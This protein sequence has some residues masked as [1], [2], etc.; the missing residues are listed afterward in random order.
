LSVLRHVRDDLTRRWTTAG[1]AHPDGASSSLNDDLSNAVPHLMLLVG[2]DFLETFAIPDLWDPNDIEEIVRDFG[3]IV[4]SRLG[5]DPQKFV[6]ESDILSKYQHNIHIVTEW[7]TNEISSTRIRRALRRGES[8]KYLVADKVISYINQY[9]L[10][11]EQPIS[12]TTNGK[13]VDSSS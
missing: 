9:Q 10:Y 7:V 1:I 13:N 3:L 11:T 5:N 8:V 4:I 2:A 12:L 6:Y